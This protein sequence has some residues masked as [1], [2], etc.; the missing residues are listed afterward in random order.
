[1]SAVPGG[2]AGTR[3]AGKRLAPEVNRIL[4]VR[5]LPFKV[6]AEQIYEIFGKVRERAFA[7]KG[8]WVGGWVGVGEET[9]ERA[10][11]RAGGRSR[12]AGAARGCDASAAARR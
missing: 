12:P 6:T 3:A 7:R 1:M 5:N 11:E 9:S 8:G 2:F 10:S 4:S